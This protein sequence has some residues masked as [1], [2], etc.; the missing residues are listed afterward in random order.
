MTPWAL[1]RFEATKPTFGPRGVPITETNDR[2]YE[3][4][5]PGT[6][7]I[8]AHPAPF[9]IIQIPGRVLLVYEYQQLT[10]HVF[11]DGRELREGIATTWMGES[12]GRWE[13]DTLVVE[14]GNF[15]E[16]TWID[17]R[18][19]PHSDQ[20]RVVERFRR[21]GGNELTLE[22]TVEDSIAFTSPWTARRVFDAVEWRIEESACLRN[23][24]FNEFER[25][26]I[27]Y[28]GE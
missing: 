25:A 7:R 14:S 20:L 13:G 3:C 10:R 16:E 1:E 6:P 5:P 18:G 9:E 11:T 2:A 28:E 8:Y 15:N 17:R 19:V 23:S 12:V 27:E 4:L 26:A 22:I 24:S 21:S